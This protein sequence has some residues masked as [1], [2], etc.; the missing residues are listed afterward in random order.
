MFKL[1]ELCHRESGRW[2]ELDTHT[3]VWKDSSGFGNLFVEAQNFNHCGGSFS[4]SLCN[5]LGLLGSKH[6]SESEVSVAF[7]YRRTIRAGLGATP[8]TSIS[9]WYSHHVC[10]VRCAQLCQ[11]EEGSW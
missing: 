8:H 10:S 1:L 11:V 6:I 7:S 3:G 2:E 9:I 5:S 4:E